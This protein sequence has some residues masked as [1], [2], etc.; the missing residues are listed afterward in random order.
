MPDTRRR[1]IETIAQLR[2]RDPD[3]LAA[4]LAAGGR[5]DSVWLV[6]AGVKVARTL[7]FRLKPGAQDAQHFKT[8]DSLA[9]YLDARTPPEG[10]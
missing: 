7:G 1:L 3:E 8:V 10:A 6:K 5:C 4:E 9:V 2:K